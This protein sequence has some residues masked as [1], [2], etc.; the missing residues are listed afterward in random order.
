M[1]GTDRYDK[2]FG[3]EKG[4]AAKAL[5]SMKKTY[6]PKGGERV[7]WGTVEKRKRRKS[8]RRWW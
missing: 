8:P 5:A 1:P 7:F 3:G 6:G 2:F 4:S